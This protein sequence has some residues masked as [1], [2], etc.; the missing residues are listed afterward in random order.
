MPA[1][2]AAALAR[3]A[4]AATSRPICTATSGSATGFAQPL[5]DTLA[6]DSTRALRVRK[7]TSGPL[8]LSRSWNAGAPKPTF[9][10]SGASPAAS[11]LRRSS[12]CACM[13]RATARAPSHG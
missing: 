4:P 7:P 3:S 13:P 10:P 11:R 8:I 9:Q 12:S 1:I 6:P 5:S 2:A